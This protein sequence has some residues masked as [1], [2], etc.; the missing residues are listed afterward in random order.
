MYKRQ[1]SIQSLAVACPSCG[2]VLKSATFAIFDEGSAKK[3]ALK[4]ANPECNQFITDAGITL[5]YYCGYVIPDSSA[6]QRSI[7]SNDL[8][9]S[10]FFENFT[11]ILTAVV[12]KECNGKP[13]AKKEFDRLREYSSMGRIKL[14]T[15]GRVEDL[16]EKLSQ[17]VRDERI[18]QSCIDY[19]A[20][21][22]TG[23]KSMS[24]FAEGRGIFNIYV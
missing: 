14:E 6:I 12:R 15:V 10:R 17:T 4:C 9:A 24:A 21:L 8:S 2:S 20:I 3:S 19:N 11:V 16:P 7:I 13:K 22:I 1:L 23:D 5:R 18:V